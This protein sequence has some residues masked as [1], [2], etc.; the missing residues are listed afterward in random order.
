MYVHVAVGAC[1]LGHVYTRRP[2]IYMSITS[3]ESITV[4]FCFF[5]V[6]WF[7]KKGLSLAWN[8]LSGLEWVTSKLLKCTCLCLAIA[9]ITGNGINIT[10]FTLDSD[11]NVSNGKPFTAKLLPNLKVVNFCLNFI[12][13][14]SFHM[15]ETL[16][17]PNFCICS[18][19]LM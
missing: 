12:K 3:E 7:L 9:R 11:S 2:E 18:V 1:A 13:I 16:C 14:I 4:L 10:F 6:V 17:L 19:N 8:F 5:C 15:T